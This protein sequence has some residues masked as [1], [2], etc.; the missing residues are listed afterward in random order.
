M[1]AGEAPKQFYD[2]DKLLGS[3]PTGVPS[4]YPAVGIVIINYNCLQLTLDCVHSLKQLAYPNFF[5]VVVD[6][7]SPDGSGYELHKH[8]R[9]ENVF[10]VLNPENRGFAA[11]NNVGIRLCEEYGAKYI[12]LLNADTV[13]ENNALAPLV[14]YLEEHKR[15][16]AVGSKVLYQVVP[17]E[18]VPERH[19]AETPV[20]WSAGGKIDFAKKQIAMTG[21]HEFD[22]GQY[23]IP[24][25]CD[26]LPGCSLLFRSD[27]L[28]RVGYMPEDYFMYFEETDWCQRI[29][30]AQYQL[31]CVPQSIV[32]HRFDDEKLN[33]PFG[34]YYYNRN[35]ALFWSRY[36][37]LKTKLTLKLKALFKDFPRAC[38]GRNAASDEQTRAIFQ[39][40]QA[41]AID[42]VLGRYGKR[43]TR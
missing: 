1:S 39:A 13:V 41:S 24:L 4:P 6:N 14:N 17:K 16:G 7:R 8:L 11:G 19:D 10:I 5:V 25:A 23:Q 40:H 35:A 27:I 21:W 22:R 29:R 20:I 34:V 3:P 33:L 42:I 32:W 31:S 30:E 18:L 2:I 37:S 12:W 15:V 38:R 43:F 26:Y 28:S 36:G 9:A